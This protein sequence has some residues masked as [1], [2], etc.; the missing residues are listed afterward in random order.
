MKALFKTNK[1][2]SAALVILALYGVYSGA[3][4]LMKSQKAPKAPSKW[5]QEL[6]SKSE[7]ILASEMGFT[8]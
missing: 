5:S 4:S 6:R 1:K 7:S 3:H 8:K 2:I